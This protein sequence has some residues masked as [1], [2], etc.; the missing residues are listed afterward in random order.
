M[1]AVVVLV[2]LRLSI[3]WHFFYQGTSKLRNESFSSEPFLRQA[4]GPFAERFQALIPDFYGLQRL[5]GETVVSGWDAYRKQFEEHYALAP[6]DRAAAKD[7]LTIRKVQLTSYLGGNA[8]AI[9]K[10]RKEVGRYRE[11]QDRADLNTVAF[12]KKRL[13]DKRQQLHA[14]SRTWLAEVD[15]INN[16]YRDDLNRLLDEDQKGRG[17][18]PQEPTRLQ[19]V[20]KL[21]TYSNLA[22]GGC[23]LIGLFTRFAALSGGLFL[24]SIVLQQPELPSVYPPAPAS[25]GRSLLINKEFIEMMA[26]FVLATTHVGR[27]GGVDFFIHRITR[28]ILCRLGGRH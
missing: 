3:G 13:W 7:M 4:K 19:R 9:D 27:W 22:I 12:E 18:V 26:M 8:D 16:S 25:A 11:A 17:P 10:Y 14:E 24:L 5:N 2:L 15:S 6:E 21:V 1:V 23:L 28:P 20:D